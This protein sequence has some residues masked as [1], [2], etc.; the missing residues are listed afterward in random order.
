M[1][2][3][4][5]RA[6]AVTQPPSPLL[7]GIGA[8]NYDYIV[9]EKELAT[10]EPE[11]RQLL[12]RFLEA[13]GERRLSDPT[14]FD[15]ILH[16]LGP[17]RYTLSYGGSAFNTVRAFA[18]LGAKL[19]LGYIGVAG[20]S[21]DS[22]SF[23]AEMDRLNID[24]SHVWPTNKE[25][26]G[27]CL[28]FVQG[29]ERRLNTLPGANQGFPTFLRKNKKAVIDYLCHAR[30]IH[31]TSLLDEESPTVLYETLAEVKGRSA[32]SISIDPG[33]V[34]VRQP[35]P[36]IL[37]LL[38]VADVLYLNEKE[39]QEL[40]TPATNDKDTLQHILRR[41]GGDKLPKLLV[42]LKRYDS[43]WLI[44]YGPS[45]MIEKPFTFPDSLPEKQIIDDTGAGDVFAAGFLAGELL[46]GLSVDD[47]IRL[48][49]SMVAAKLRSAGDNG[50]KRFGKLLQAFTTKTAGASG[51]GTKKDMGATKAG[52]VSAAGRKEVFVVH[53]RDHEGRREAVARLIEQRS[54][55][56]ATLLAEEPA[57]GATLIELLENKRGVSFVVV[58]MTG[59][60]VGAAKT[61]ARK[62]KPRA[63]QNVVFELGF[64]VAISRKHVCLLYEKGVEMPTDYMG[65]KYI[66]ID[67]GEGWKGQLNQALQAA[68]L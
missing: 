46:P 56:K 24:H 49:R 17:A 40:G 2:T 51:A 21:V 26:A 6:K 45:G 52:G 64:F 22:L 18:L 28:S 4:T 48:G 5:T 30:H 27:Q 63:R 32:V 65:V 61:E 53:G 38:A 47:G 44:G 31:V 1:A 36:A 67:P 7:V 59:D 55:L 34:W 10:S 9:P 43:I 13:G 37:Q 54:G 14:E 57:T 33:H 62:L 68:G 19:P 23:T 15:A 39:F 66:E 58:I 42:V 12:H 3:R 41:I 50:Y 11:L 16:E 25:R 60:D 20:A 8:L 29:G 35:K